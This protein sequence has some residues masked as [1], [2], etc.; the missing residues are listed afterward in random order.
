MPRAVV[1]ALSRPPE[2]R[3]RTFAHWPG[4]LVP[5]A[6]RPLI[7]HALG[8]LRD[9]GIRE[10]AVVADRALAPRLRAALADGEPWDLGITHVPAASGGELAA[11]AG[12]TEFLA[13]ETAVVHRAEALVGRALGDELADFARHDADARVLTRTPHPGDA[14]PPGAGAA[15]G[16]LGIE[17]LAPG[18]LPRLVELVGP[19]ERE[20]SLLDALERLAADGGARVQQRSVPGSWALGASTDDVLEGHRFV[21]DAIEPAWDPGVLRDA[22]VEG[23]VV[24]DPSSVVE[25]SLVRGP[26]VIGPGV[27]LRDAYVGPYTAV[28]AGSSIENAEI[29]HSIVLRDARLNDV[30]W[31]LERSIIGDRA[32][33]SRAFRLPRAVSLCLGEDAEISAA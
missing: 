23:R 31:R 22:Q 5:L 15:T 20:L 26:V 8:G 27:C 3:R 9:A 17:L 12:L 32:R 25:R 28:G 16:R 18:L 4:P 2:P 29:E 21:L 13:G 30:P 7:H 11:L 14:A 6:N 1:L 24:I 19:N 10:I 33:V